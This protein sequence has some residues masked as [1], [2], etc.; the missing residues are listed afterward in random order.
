MLERGERLDEM[1][2]KSESMRDQAAVFR[3]KGRALRRQM[4]WSNAKWSIALALV[5][6]LVAFVVFLAA[7]GGFKCVKKK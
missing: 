5:V 1:A 4:W 3:A 6:V 2:A 7:C